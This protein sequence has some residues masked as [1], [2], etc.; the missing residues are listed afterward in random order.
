MDESG[1][2]YKLSSNYTPRIKGDKYH[3]RTCSKQ[4]LTVVL[5]GNA[6]SSDKHHFKNINSTLLIIY[7][8]NKK[9]WI[10]SSTF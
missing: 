2:F 6:D 10:D 3:G 1:I 5:L 8:H 4:H 9:V 7:S